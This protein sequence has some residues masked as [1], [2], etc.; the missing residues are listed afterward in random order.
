LNA[1]AL[2][3]KKRTRYEEAIPLQNDIE[4]SANS[5]QI[6]LPERFNSAEQLDDFLS[7]P[8]P[9]LIKDLAAI[10]GDIL[11]LGV[12]GKM[13]P[14][15]ARMARNAAPEKRILGV[16]RFSEQGVRER[17]EGWGIETQLVD[18]LDAKQVQALPRMKNVIYMAG[19]KFGATD[20]QP[21]TWATNVHAAAI[22]AETFSRSRI[23][24]FSTGNIYPL[25]DLRQA[26]QGADEKTSPQPM[27]EYAQSCLGRERMFQ[28][29]SSRLATPGRIFR[30]NYALEL[31]YGVLFDLAQRIARGDPIDISMGHV[32]VIWQGDA[33]DQALRLL[34]HCTEPTTPI[35]VTGPQTLSIRWLAQELANRLDI[36]PQI[37]GAEASTALL[38]DSSQCVELLGSP[39]VP[40]DA[41][42]DWVADW[43]AQGQV[44]FNKPTK[45]EVRDGKF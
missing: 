35:N 38:S 21:L 36:N 45:Y 6:E 31:R 16:A 1:K 22:T 27:G 37:V 7:T 10:D 19:M 42:L 17:L 15:L 25:V 30:L 20:N 18:L 28:Y 23:V 24:A 12:A 9:A 43:V 44:S 40:L 14:T 39:R 11:I 3:R 2:I 26:R 13:G 41:M 32:N 29:F 8:S 4:I 34:R 33:N 5:A